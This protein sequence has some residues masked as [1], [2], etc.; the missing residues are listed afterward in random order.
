MRRRTSEP[1]ELS[2]YLEELAAADDPPTELDSYLGRLRQGG[3]VEVYVA[4]QTD[5]GALLPISTAEQEQGPPVIVVRARR[6]IASERIDRQESRTPVRDALD[7]LVREFQAFDRIARFRFAARDMEL[8]SQAADGLI[9][10]EAGRGSARAF[11]R[12]IETGMV[13]TY[14]RPFL[15]SNE[16]G[17]PKGWWPTDE[18]ERRLHDELIDLRGEYHAHATHTP[19]RRLEIMH[20]FTESGRPILAESWTELPVW[21]LELLNRIATQQAERFKAEAERLDLELFGPHEET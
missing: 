5:P 19:Q 7:R 15:P 9:E 1:L 17:L 21:K 10:A 18:E 12:V 4:R 20:G 13:V 8:A 2:P 6:F 16:A 11:Q 3:A 14:A